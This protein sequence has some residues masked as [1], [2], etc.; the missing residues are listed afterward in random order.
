MSRKESPR[1]PAIRITLLPRDT[2]PHGTIFG[3]IILSYIDQ[4]GAVAAKRVTRRK[5]VTVSMHEVV[6]KKPVYV[7][8]LI[9]FYADV[10]KVGRTSIATR[11]VV[12]AQ[13]EGDPEEIVRVTEADVVFVA[14]DDAGNP[15]PV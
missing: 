6:F 13:R 9:S 2:N 5:V 3:G 10:T 1:D 14:V 11:V 7:G 12:E 15:V 4:A 8:D